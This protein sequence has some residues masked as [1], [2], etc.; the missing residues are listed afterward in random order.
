MNV[1]PVG[2]SMVLFITALLSTLGMGITVY[3]KFSETKNATATVLV[4][5]LTGLLADIPQAYVGLVVGSK[6]ASP[7]QYLVYSAAGAVVNVLVLTTRLSS[8]LIRRPSPEGDVES[9]PLVDA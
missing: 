1:L 3:Q 6:C 8:L 9:A 5:V 4:M 2:L 7:D